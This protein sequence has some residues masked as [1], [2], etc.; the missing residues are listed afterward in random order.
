M[1]DYKIIQSNCIQTV[2]KEETGEFMG[3]RLV[4]PI[5]KKN[6]DRMQV[7]KS[8]GELD[9]IYGKVLNRCQFFKR[10]WFYVV[11]NL[12]LAQLPKDFSFIVAERKT[13]MIIMREFNKEVLTEE[14][15]S[16]R[17]TGNKYNVEELRSQGNLFEN[18]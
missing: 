11:G 1:S 4:F 9:G 7:L 16:I 12:S 2:L 5:S 8:R 17:I 3:Y 6:Y 13:M 10:T 14:I 15:N 18:I